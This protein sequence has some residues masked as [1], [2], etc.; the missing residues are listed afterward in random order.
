MTARAKP[1]PLASGSV[2]MPEIMRWRSASAPRPIAATPEHIAGLQ[3]WMQPITT[4]PGHHP[5]GALQAAL[6]ML[7]DAVFK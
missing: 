1:C 3:Q 4:E 7:P 5:W 2:T 6:Q